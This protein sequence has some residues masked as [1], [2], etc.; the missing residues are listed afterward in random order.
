MG[1]DIKC[2]RG[3]KG[4]WKL[5]PVEAETGMK[6]GGVKIKTAWAR[7]LGQVGYEA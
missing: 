6:T 3:G 7:Q 5:K 4:D 1:A 2:G